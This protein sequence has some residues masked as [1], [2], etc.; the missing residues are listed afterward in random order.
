MIRMG[1]GAEKV[2][3]WTLLDGKNDKGCKKG[4]ELENNGLW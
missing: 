4:C 2:R 3:C 1:K